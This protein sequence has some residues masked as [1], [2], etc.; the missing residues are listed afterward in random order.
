MDKV[1]K[2]KGIRDEQKERKRK[3]SETAKLEGRMEEVKKV[4]EERCKLKG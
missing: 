2:K 3:K 4:K 1:R